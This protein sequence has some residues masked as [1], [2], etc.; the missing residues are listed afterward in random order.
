MQRQGA[1]IFPPQPLVTIAVTSRTVLYWSDRGGLSFNLKN[2]DTK[3]II[4]ES[5]Q[6]AA[7]KVVDACYVLLGASSTLK[8]NVR[9]QFSRLTFQLLPS[10]TIIVFYSSTSVKKKSVFC[11]NCVLKDRRW[12]SAGL[13]WKLTHWLKCDVAAHRG[14]LSSLLMVEFCHINYNVEVVE[15]QR[16]RPTWK[17]VQ[18]LMTQPSLHESLMS[19]MLCLFYSPSWHFSQK[20]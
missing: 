16:W 13:R 15:L 9:E 8:Y 7:L 11:A 10:K 4:R 1:I 12:I 17:Q 2:R 19:S 14:C 5:S 6:T 3:Q 20:T 18:L